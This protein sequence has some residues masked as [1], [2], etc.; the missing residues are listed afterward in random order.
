MFDPRFLVRLHHLCSMHRYACSNELG[1]HL[2]YAVKAGCSYFIFQARRSTYT[3]LRA[4]KM[5]RGYRS[6]YEPSSNQCSGSL[7]TNL[8]LNRWSS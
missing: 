6:R 4:A 1:S 8:R 3:K 7:R 2:F 5:Y